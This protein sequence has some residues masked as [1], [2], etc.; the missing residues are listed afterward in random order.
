MEPAVHLRRITKR[1]GALLAN[2]AIDLTVA[3]GDLHAIVG[4]NGAGKTTL[5]HILCGLL[6]PDSGEV[7]VEGRALPPGDPRAALRAGV[8]LVAQHFSLVPTLTVWE[9]VVLG[10]EPARWGRLDRRRAIARTAAL[11]DRLGVTLPL[12][13]PVETLPIGLQQTVEIL[14][15]LHRRARILILDEP[16]SS[17]SPPEAGRLFDLVARLRQAGATILLV[18]HR[19]RE[20]QDHATR[21]TVL[22]NGRLVQTFNRDEIDPAPLVRAIVGSP[23]SEPA[24]AFGAPDRP[25][26][27]PRSGEVRL[28]IHNLTVSAQGHTPV[29]RLSLT[30]HRGEMLGLAGVVGN[31]QQELVGALTGQ[32]PVR[33]GRI[34]LNGRDLTRL[35][36]AARRAAGLCLIPEDRQAEGLIPAFSLRDNLIL[37]NQRDYASLRGLNFPAMAARA[38]DL[39]D[40]FDIRTTGPL[41]PAARLSGGNQ[42]KAVIARELSRNPDLVLAVQPTRGLDLKATAF[43]HDQLKA[44][45]AR[46]G[47]ILLISSDLEELLALSDR[48]A[49]IYRGRIAGDLPRNAFDEETLGKMM[50]G[51][52]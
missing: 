48:I 16:T 34:L 33:S 35:P 27:A 31:G 20:V 7:K 46:G 8:G 50:T 47:S 9:N 12:D 17:L 3:P 32:L 38:Q 23:E 19:L 14:K 22:R 30:L 13:A 44:V 26:P 41:Q 42:Q 43:L 49:A 15:A 21:A 18:T 37:G 4:E 51:T 2:D 10:R 25:E 11:A 40:R 45:C 1:Y 6:S 28:Q 24:P 5:M 29:D 39:M 52:D 36:V